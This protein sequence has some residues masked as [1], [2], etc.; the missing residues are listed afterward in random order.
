MAT[1]PSQKRPN[2]LSVNRNPPVEVT[3]PGSSNSLNN[4]PDGAMIVNNAKADKNKFKN[5]KSTKK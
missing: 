2:N 3:S 4:S 5:A 1:N